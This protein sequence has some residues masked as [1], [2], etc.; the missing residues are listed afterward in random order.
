M[1]VDQEKKKKQQMPVYLR[2]CPISGKPTLS[3]VRVIEDGNEEN[4]GLWYKSPAGVIFQSDKP[5]KRDKDVKYIE[6]H[7]KVKENEEVYIHSART[8]VN[9]IEE[10]TYGR[11]LLDVG[12][13]TPHVMDFFSKRGWISFGMDFNKDTEET[14][15]IMKADF[16]KTTEIYERTYDLVWMSFVLEQFDDP[17]AS[18]VKAHK[19]LQD[20]GVIFISTPDIDFLYNEPNSW[21]HWRSGEHNIMW[22]EDALCRELEKI[23]FKIIVKR[24]N[25]AS[26]FGYHHD[27]QIVAQKSFF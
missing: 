12:F 14:D 9:V 16:E 27:L 8:Y 24:R 15:R 3:A 11:K 17:L 19:V 23:G 5:D 18:L 25:F 10:L 7:S 20:D 26:R 2:K 1:K 13:C 22:S 21:S 6:A 4:I